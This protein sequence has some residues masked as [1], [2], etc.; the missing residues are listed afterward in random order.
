MVVMVII[1]M[2]NG[3]ASI[4]MSM[5]IFMVIILTILIIVIAIFQTVGFKLCFQTSATVSSGFCANT[6]ASAPMTSLA[7]D[8]TSENDGDDGDA[9]DIARSAELQKAI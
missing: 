6:V 5:I 2:V 9:D 3:D 8:A 7:L 4:T 1:M